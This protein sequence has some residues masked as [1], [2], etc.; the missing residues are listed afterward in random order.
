M[1]LGPL[2]IMPMKMGF[3]TVFLVLLVPALAAQS[4]TI[5]CEDNPPFQYKKDGVLTGFMVELVQHLQKAVVNTDKIEVV[6]WN[7]GYSM[8]LS[9]PNVML[10]G[11]ARTPARNDLFQWVGPTHEGPLAL[12]VRADYAGRLE[13]LEDAKAVRSIGVSLNDVRDVLLTAAGL[14]NLVRTSDNVVNLRQTMNGRL[15]A[16]A[17]SD[18]EIREL[19][20]KEGLKPSQIRKAFDFSASWLYI[21]VSKGTPAS[22][23]HDWNAALDHLKADGTFSHLYQ[24]YFPGDAEPGMAPAH[25]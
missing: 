2:I 18:T 3:L 7:R 17:S 16:F 19:I 12:Y 23:A 22:V 14:T 13:N 1:W 11:M 9:K 21:A 5:Y 4:L 20:A 15:D 25:F 6:P 8:A 24:K 10:F